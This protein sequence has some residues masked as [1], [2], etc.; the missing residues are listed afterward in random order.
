MVLTDRRQSW[1]YLPVSNTAHHTTK[2]TTMNT[3]TLQNEIEDVETVRDADG[4]IEQIVVTAFSASLCASVT[5]T[6]GHGHFTVDAINGEDVSWS[7]LT[8]STVENAIETVFDVAG[9]SWTADE[10]AFAER[11]V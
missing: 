1:H 6:F 10:Q 8:D 11:T 3:T 4:D 2:D 5:V 7:D 9:P